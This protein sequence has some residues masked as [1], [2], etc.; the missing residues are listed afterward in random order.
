MTKKNSGINNLGQKVAI[1]A[2]IQVVSTILNSFAT[3]QQYQKPISTESS[4]ISFAALTIPGAIGSLGSSLYLKSN[5]DYNYLYLGLHTIPFT[6]RT[7][8]Y[9]MDEP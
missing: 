8:T 2:A 5:D 9:F 3:Y 6:T 1:V 4:I 7:I